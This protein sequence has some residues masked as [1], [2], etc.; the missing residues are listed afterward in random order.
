MSCLIIIS[1]RGPCVVFLAME[2]LLLYLLYI[3]TSKNQTQNINLSLTEIAGCVLRQKP[4][5]QCQISSIC[6]G[7]QQ[8]LSK[9]SLNPFVNFKLVHYE[10]NSNL[11]GL[12]RGTSQLE[13]Q[14]ALG[15]TFQLNETALHCKLISY[16]ILIANS[17]TQFEYL[18]A[19]F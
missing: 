1:F 15:I 14:R 4:N 19:T 17:Y 10:M 13:E 3:F 6:F 8:G 7:N 18:N 2:F 11:S 5:I 16:E 9:K 12:V